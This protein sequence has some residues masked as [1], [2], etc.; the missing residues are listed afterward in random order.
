M[1]LAHRLRKHADYQRAYA[2][3]RKGSTRQIT[4]FFATREVVGAPV[5]T[6]GIAA[7]VEGPRVGLTVPK[8]V[9]KAHE[10]NRIKR[11]MRAIIRAELGL[12]AGGAVDVILHPRRST[13]EA[14]FAV[15][16][17]EVAEIFGR[18]T[19]ALADPAAMS[20]PRRDDRRPDRGKARRAN[21]RSKGQAG[22]P[23]RNQVGTRP[24]APQGSR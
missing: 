14:E 15:L 13:M 16:E 5:Q 18:V 21:D 4:Y 12:L 23:A 3:S 17:R 22:T 8:A 9:G 11:R 2:R 10:R 20:A 1:S 24:G 7:P 19:R 6:G